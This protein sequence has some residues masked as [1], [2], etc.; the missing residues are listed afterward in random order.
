MSRHE[1]KYSGLL[2]IPGSVLAALE[3]LQGVC[4]RFCLQSGEGERHKAD[5]WAQMRIK[6]PVVGAKESWSVFWGSPIWLP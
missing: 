4:S 2:E 3:S 1:T 5:L 6:E